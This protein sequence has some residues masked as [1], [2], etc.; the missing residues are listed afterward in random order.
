MTP[1][2]VDTRDPSIGGKSEPPQGRL[3][4]LWSLAAVTALAAAGCATAP[5]Q[6][7]GPAHDDQKTAQSDQAAPANSHTDFHEKATERQ[8]FQVHIDFGRAFETQGNL[9]AAIQEYQD[10][11]KVVENKERGPVPGGRRRAGAST[12]GQRLRSYWPV[13]PGRNS[14]SEGTQAQPERPQDLERRRV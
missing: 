5:R 12:N 6:P 14:L 4:M 9:D 7:E 10:A 13:R 8:Q 1:G 11:L 2:P 3:I